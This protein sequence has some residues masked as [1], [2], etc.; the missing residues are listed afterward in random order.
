MQKMWETVNSSENVLNIIHADNETKVVF[1]PWHSSFIIEQT[2]REQCTLYF[3]FFKITSSERWKCKK[4]PIYHLSMFCK[5]CIFVIVLSLSDRRK[6]LFD[7]GFPQRGRPFHSSF[8]RGGC[9]PNSV[10]LKKQ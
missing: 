10:L 2:C 6:A 8:Q 4:I 7:P 3:L 5:T 9:E 1:C